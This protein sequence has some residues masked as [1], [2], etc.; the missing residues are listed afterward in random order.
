MIDDSRLRSRT[1]PKVV[2][3]VEVYRKYLI[4]SDQARSVEDAYR[5]VC[6]V[7]L[8]IRG[9]AETI[10]KQIKLDQLISEATKEG[11]ILTVDSEPR[12]VIFGGKEYQKKGN[13]DFHRNI[14][15]KIIPCLVFSNK[16]YRLCRPETGA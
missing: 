6:R 5:E 2:K 7:L 9:M 13:W 11:S 14:L 4:D 8:K 1:D 3:Q 16:P 10:G 15:E 12:L